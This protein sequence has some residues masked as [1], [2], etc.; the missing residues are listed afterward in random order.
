MTWVPRDNRQTPPTQRVLFETL[1]G[2]PATLAPTPYA[3][4]TPNQ[5]SAAADFP[6][7]LTTTLAAEL[8]HVAPSTSMCMALRN[9]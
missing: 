3:P 4:T 6:L 2:L 9:P 7:L 5:H 1:S 8:T